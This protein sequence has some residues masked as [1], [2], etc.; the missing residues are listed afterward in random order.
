MEKYWDDGLHLS[1]EG[2]NWMG[3]HIA[4]AFIPLAQAHA[5]PTATAAAAVEAPKPERRRKARGPKVYGDEAS[6]EEEDGD[7]K[8]LTKGYVVVRKRDLE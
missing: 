4:D 1:E 7:P 2:Y 5:A 3:G 8:K 6:V